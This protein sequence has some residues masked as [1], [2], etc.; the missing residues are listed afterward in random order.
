MTSD[1]RLSRALLARLTGSALVALAL[2]VLLATLVVA[3]AGLP[4]VVVP[5]VGLV[6][7]AALGAAAYWLSRLA[8]VRLEE[9]GYR[10]RLVRGVGVAQARWVAVEGA[11]TSYAADQPLVELR[12]RD[13]R[14]T[15]IPVRAL[16]A[17]REEFV[18][19]LQRHLQQGHGLR[20]L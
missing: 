18:R 9:G 10:V 6:G 20:R 12:L 2:L 8:V 11:A 14:R 3:A 4:V 17:D 15:L 19:D 1:Y 13:G 7:V 16:E 5:A